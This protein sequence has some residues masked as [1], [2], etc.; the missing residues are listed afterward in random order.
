MHAA[1]QAWQAVAAPNE[2]PGSAAAVNAAKGKIFVLDIETDPGILAALR[3]YSLVVA[4]DEFDAMQ[5]TG[6]SVN[7]TD[8][9]GALGLY[10][11]DLDHENDDSAAARR[12]SAYRFLNLVDGI[13]EHYRDVAQ[14]DDNLPTTKINLAQRPRRSPRAD[15]ASAGAF[16]DVIL[17]IRWK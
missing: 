17:S 16:F 12:R 9:G 3:P 10:V 2:T 4:T 14:T 15:D 8:R 13:T 1:C 11:C 6:G 5:F 7:Y